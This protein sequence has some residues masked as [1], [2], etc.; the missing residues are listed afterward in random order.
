MI[1]SSRVRARL[2]PLRLMV[3]ER[4]EGE[5]IIDGLVK[6][7]REIE[8]MRDDWTGWAVGSKHRV[9]FMIRFSNAFS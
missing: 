5:A 7:G 4:L 2:A 1:S 6:V 9:A 8:L 3:K